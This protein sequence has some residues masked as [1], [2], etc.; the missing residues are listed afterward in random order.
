MTAR[1]LHPRVGVGLKI[2]QRAV[3]LIARQ[4]RDGTAQGDLTVSRLAVTRLK[5]HPVPVRTV[6]RTRFAN[7]LVSTMSDA[8]NLRK[9]P[10]KWGLQ[11]FVGTARRGRLFVSR[12]PKQAFIVY[13][14]PKSAE[15][16]PLDS[17][18]LLNNN[19]FAIQFLYDSC[20]YRGL[21][22]GR[23]KFKKNLC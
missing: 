1:A 2:W 14:V 22:W 8:G 9:H 4:G 23:R 5:Y 7:R 17:R 12:V 10:L 19:A 16:W 6:A 20:N 11:W 13:A 18:L 15:I 3:Q 21:I